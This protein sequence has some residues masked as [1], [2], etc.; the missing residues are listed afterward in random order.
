V[1]PAPHVGLDKVG[2]G[3]FS[4]GQSAECRCERADIGRYKNGHRMIFDVD[5]IPRPVEKVNDVSPAVIFLAGM[6]MAKL[7]SS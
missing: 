2:S 4:I 1:N 7:A 3:L 5:G 6:F